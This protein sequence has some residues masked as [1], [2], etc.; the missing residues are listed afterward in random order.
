MNLFF[1]RRMTTAHKHERARQNGIK[2]G[3]VIGPHNPSR[4]ANFA[5]F[6]MAVHLFQRSAEPRT[7]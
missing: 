3:Q 1:W 6:A 2:H 7:A 5:Q 4:P